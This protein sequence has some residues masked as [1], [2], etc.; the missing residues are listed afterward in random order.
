M[1][2]KGMLPGSVATVLVV[3]AVSGCGD[4]LS[5]SDPQRYTDSDLNSALP[6]VAN[7][8]EGAMHADMDI[9]V[10]YQ[11]LLADEY[12]HTGT[13]TNYDE[14]DH[15]RITFG[16]NNPMRF[17]HDNWL[18]A[19]RFA[20]EAEER[21]KAELGEAEAASSELTAQVRLAGAFAD[22]YMGMA[23]CEGVGE[24]DGPVLSDTQLLQQ[25][26][27]K[28][29]DAM[30]T[31]QSAGR[32]DYVT[33]ARA[34]R[35]QA[36]LVLDRISEAATDAAAIPDG[37]VYEAVFNQNATNAV[38][39]LTTKNFNEAA[40]LMHS[41]WDAIELSDDPGFMRD[42]WTGEFDE[43]MPVYFDGEVATDNA[44]PHYSQWKY[45]AL[46]ANIPMVH[47]DGM[48]LIEA[49]A[50]A[51]NGDLAS[52]TAVLNELREAVDLAPLDVAADAPTML[53]YLMTERF[54]ELFMEGHRAVD[55]YRWDLTEAVFGEIDDPDRPA[56]DRPTKFPMSYNEALYNANVED[57]LNIRCLPTS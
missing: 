32:T 9:Y 47:S 49:E 3:V 41:W 25:A 15:G 26:A 13:W 6:A 55:L 36:N 35:A 24:A 7:G 39:N 16:P 34:G 11:A 31:A 1:N 54:A 57:D 38:V 17:T 10:I 50:M 14:T 21:F 22:L 51:A 30:Q 23:F 45:H 27:Q 33:A 44:T 4:L 48:R 29:T 52:A 2:G 40:G 20:T 43:R 56:A 46:T 18:I 37:F 5:V 19:Q 28:F 8:V 12:Q 53:R 42:P